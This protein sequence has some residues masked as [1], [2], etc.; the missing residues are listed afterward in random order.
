MILEVM[1]LEDKVKSYEG[2]N[3]N[4]K[5][6]E[7]LAMAGDAG[8]ISRLK[9]ELARTK[10]DLATLKKQSEGLHKSWDEV[11]DKYATT[12]QQGDKKSN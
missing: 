5:E 1:R 3:K 12:V 10:E 8:E 2:T 6:S 4:T 9:K 7:K 11:S